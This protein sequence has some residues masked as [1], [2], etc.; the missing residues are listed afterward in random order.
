MG[1]FTAKD[2]AW[3]LENCP[4]Q[5]VAVIILITLS[6]W[7]TW[8]VN[9]VISKALSREKERTEEI[10]A[11][12]KHIARQ[13]KQQ[14]KLIQLITQAACISK[15]NGVWLGDESR[16]GDQPPDAIRCLYLDAKRNLTP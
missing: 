11:L 13:D 4:P 5:L 8:R 10:E 15:A 6:A 14:H 16:N 1:G 2:I 9:V 7:L 3:A 12:K